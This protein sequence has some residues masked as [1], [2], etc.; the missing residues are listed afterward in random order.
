MV[1]EFEPYGVAESCESSGQA[2][3]TNIDLSETPFVIKQEFTLRGAGPT[4]DTKVGPNKQ[5]VD[6]TGG[7]YCGSNGPADWRYFSPRAQP[8]W[9]MQLELR[10]EAHAEKK[11]KG[12]VSQQKAEQ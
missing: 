9:V 1:Y 12:T 5:T 10:P 4:G 7:G 8:Q 2:G 11:N 3:K 6:L